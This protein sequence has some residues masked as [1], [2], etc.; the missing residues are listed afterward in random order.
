[1]V[2]GRIRAGLAVL[3][4]VAFTAP[5]F[6]QAPALTGSASGLTV[7]LNW[8]AVPQATGYDV[9]A[10]L[11]GTPLGPIPVGNV[12]TISV[13]VPAGV[14]DI[15]VRGT[16]GAITGPVSN[17]V[18]LT[19][20]LTPPAAPSELGAAVNGNDVLL[21]WAGQTAGVQSFVVQAGQAAGGGEL[22]A[23][24]V[25]VT[26]SLAVGGLAS[27]SYFVRTFAVGAGGV[28]PASNEASFSLPGCVAPA[29]LPLTAT[30]SGSYVRMSWPAVPGATGYR[31]DV[32]STPAGGADIGSFPFSG[33]ETSFSQIGAP[34]GTFYLTLHTA[35]S[36]GATAQSAVTLLNVTP[37]VRPPAQS[38]AVIEA[39]VWEAARAIAAQYPGDLRNSDVKTGGNNNYMFRVLQRLRQQN[40]RFGLNWKRGHVGDLSQDVISYIF[41][42]AP[43]E[44]ADQNH[45]WMWDI[46][47]GHGGP[48]PGPNAQPIWSFKIAERWT[49][50]PYLNR[51]FAP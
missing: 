21:T 11:N 43:E 35:M 19:A 12:T 51:N 34:L 40:N 13:P 47:S 22:G 37:P 49:I 26:N 25:G 14:Y 39:M 27:G 7:T 5:A 1:M 16:A 44:L 3:A 29:T 45:L 4:L 6:A 31:L 42:D 32:A 18:T 30:S 28:S 17:P 24:P 36:C 48:N 9:V 38:I 8:T 2:L 15:T 33:T 20:A 10:S 50:L 41:D 46:I 23:F